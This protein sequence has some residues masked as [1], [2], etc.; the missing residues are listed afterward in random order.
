MCPVGH[1]LYQ[2]RLELLQL[3]L[4][5]NGALSHLLNI[6]ILHISPRLYRPPCED[7]VKIQGEKMKLKKVY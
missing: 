1:V 3:L 2:K 4:N 6:C 7:N 5:V